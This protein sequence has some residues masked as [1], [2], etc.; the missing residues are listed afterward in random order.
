[1]DEHAS[2]LDMAAAIRNMDVSPL[3]VLDDCLARVDERNPGLNAV[4]W[5]NDDQAR[6]EARALGDRIAAG[7]DDLPP[8]AGVPL[9]IKDLLPVAG[10]PVT[11][12]SQG[13]PAGPS[14]VS[15]LIAEAFVRAG[16]VL[17]GRTN[18]PEFGSI[19]VTENSRFGATRNPWD[20]EHTPGGSSGGAAAAVASRMFP[21]AH[22]GDG[23]GSIRIPASCCGL[24]GL[25]PSRGRVASSVPMWQGMATEGA[26]TRTVADAASVLD[27]ISA[28]DPH[29][30][31]NA[32]PPARPF[33]DE[34]GVAP[35]QLTVALC[36]T[37][38]LGLTVAEGPLAAVD[39][40][41][42]VLEEC[43]HKVSVLDA[44]VF[45]PAGLGPF[46]NVINAGLGD[47]AGID[48][49]RVE[50]HNRAAYAT[51]EG[52]DSLTF[53]RSLADLQRMTR[54]IVAR[55]D[56][57]FDLLV[58][59]TMCVEPPRVGLLDEVHASAASGALPLE[60]VAMAAF[61]A[62]HNITGLPAVSLPLWMAPSG[63]PVGVQ[64]VA[65]PWREDLLVR[66][67]SQLEQ[68]EPWADRY[69]RF[70]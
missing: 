32:P 63:L 69:P 55:F 29:G 25:K 46:L 15:E 65:P 68:A 48:W 51:A 23:G 33:A 35:G 53:V 67:A 19:T 21:V 41:G 50:P 57:E 62:V 39:H 4:I 1:M 61:T 7:T 59:P 28:P 30:W 54:S 26:L 58:T 10:Q 22:G 8:F 40:A 31:W 5:R 43:G 17:T 16:F 34:V 42:H 18:T 64:V 20:P 52:V 27:V 12:G 2:A 3:E 56:H 44:D 45:D 14:E 6:A 11:F 70:D 66:V 47:A 13:A 37:S 36:R 49:D 9:P 60:I 38:A 24:V